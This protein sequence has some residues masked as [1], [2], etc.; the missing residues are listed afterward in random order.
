MALVFDDENPDTKK[1]LVFDDEPQPGV[2][3]QIG[4]AAG[5]AGQIGLELL[6][7]P[8]EL[9]GEA[10]RMAGNGGAFR[11]PTVTRHLGAINGTIPIPGTSGYPVTNQEQPATFVG[12]VASGLQGLTAGATAPLLGQNPVIAANNEL[13]RPKTTIPDQILQTGLAAAGGPV[14]NAPMNAALRVGGAVLPVVG[15]GAAYA[16]SAL[17][18]VPP[19]NYQTVFNDPG[20]VL[21]GRM[22]Q[23]G[24]DFEAA[25][26]ATGVTKDGVPIPPTGPLTKVQLDQVTNGSVRQQAMTNSENFIFKIEKKINNGEAVTPEEALY[27]RQAVDKLTP[28]PTAKN[29]NYR[30]M[31]QD[32]RN[33]FQQVI[34]QTPLGPASQ[35]YAVAKAGNNFL[36]PVPLTST[37]KPAFV[38]TMGMLGSIYEGHPMAAV[39]ASPAVAGAA[40]AGLGA[41]AIPV[42]AFANSDAMKAALLAALVNNRKRRNQ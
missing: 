8:N 37:G 10:V 41:A 31:L 2:M 19:S 12:Q 20:A 33:K 13:Q 14:M 9:A 6:N 38:R 18:N 11:L 29:A 30:S 15:K 42:K 7:A 28:L 4:A 34:G 16:S 3:S 22:A 36:S 24:E 39:A 1:K 26:N 40:T 25:K 23:A 5:K 35:G 17:T 32:M 21:P 27:A